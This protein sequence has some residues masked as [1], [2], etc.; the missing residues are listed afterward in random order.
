MYRKSSNKN[1]M[2]IFVILMNPPLNKSRICRSNPVQ[3][4]DNQVDLNKERMGVFKL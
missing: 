4:V 3:C 1:P 2:L